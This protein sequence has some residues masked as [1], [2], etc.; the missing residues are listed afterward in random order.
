MKFST[1]F[2]AF[3][4]AS[5]AAATSSIASTSTAPSSTASSGPH[6]TT[7][8][9]ERGGFHYSLSTDDPNI[10]MFPVCVM[11]RTRYFC[12]V[13][14]VDRDELY[15]FVMEMLQE[16]SDSTTTSGPVSTTSSNAPAPTETAGSQSPQIAQFDSCNFELNGWV[17]QMDPVRGSEDADDVAAVRQ[18]SANL[19]AANA[20]AAS[21]ES[22]SVPDATSMDTDESDEEYDEEIEMEPK[23][24][25]LA[26]AE[27]A[28]NSGSLC[29]R[30][31][32]CKCGKNGA[33]A[34]TGAYGTGAYGTGV[35][36]PTGTGVAYPTGT[37]AINPSG[38][39][40]GATDVPTAGAK[41]LA[42]PLAGLMIAALAL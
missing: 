41:Q 20:E 34:A 17:C 5:L 35:A 40:V 10:R 23:P 7:L 6:P 9:S 42:V 39:G 38:S 2:S 12:A 22:S 26:R 18:A 1:I 25:V 4:A 14:E 19:Y 13:Y 11:V 16:A 27:E 28:G 29:G 32:K 21:S 15:D 3:S 33:A 30:C 36:H 8:S 31:S 37:G 24:S